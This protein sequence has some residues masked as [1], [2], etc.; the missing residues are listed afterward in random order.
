MPARSSMATMWRHASSA[1]PAMSA[2]RLPS[3]ARPGVPE[4]NS[5]RAC[6]GTSTA[7]L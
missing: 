2:G 7:S 3:S 1:W 6:G 4:V 5:Q